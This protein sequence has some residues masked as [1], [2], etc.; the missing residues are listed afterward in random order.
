MEEQKVDATI[1]WKVF[2]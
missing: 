1:I 2:V